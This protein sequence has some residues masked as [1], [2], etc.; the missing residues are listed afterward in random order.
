MQDSVAVRERAMEGA[1]SGLAPPAVR[2]TRGALL[3]EVSSCSIEHV[4][5]KQTNTC[6]GWPNRGPCGVVGPGGSAAS[7]RWL[8]RGVSRKR[9]GRGEEEDVGGL[10]EEV[11]VGEGLHVPAEA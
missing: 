3:P 5:H 9:K 1:S 7:G 4:A 2:L 11:K 10:E 8:G 6:S